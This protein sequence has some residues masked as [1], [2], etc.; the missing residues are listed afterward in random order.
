MNKLAK[1]ISE[2]TITVEE[3]AEAGTL[4]SRAQFVTD[5]LKACQRTILFPLGKKEI[6]VYDYTDRAGEYHSWGI[7]SCN[8]TFTCK[9][10]WC[11][12]HTVGSVNLLSFTD[13]FM[14]LEDEHFNSDLTRFLQQQ[15][16]KLAKND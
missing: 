14:A 1:M 11:G 8:G 5:A 12:D 13:V 3:L 2:G 6:N 9:A 16:D 7:C 4:I 10:N 15:I